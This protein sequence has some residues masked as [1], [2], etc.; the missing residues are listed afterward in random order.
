MSLSEPVR[1]VLAQALPL[2]DLGL[3]LPQRPDGPFP[4]CVQSPPLFLPAHFGTSAMSR[5]H[6]S[7]ARRHLLDGLSP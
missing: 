2:R 1:L 4:N 3:R 7:A 5:W 6:E